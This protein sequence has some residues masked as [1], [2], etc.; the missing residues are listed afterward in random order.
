MN[1]LTSLRD[2]GEALDQE[3]RGPSP[4]LRHTVLTGI[5]AQHGRALR[6]RTSSG[7]SSRSSTAAPAARAPAR[8]LG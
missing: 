2:L 3:L 8:A 1:E 6:A 4:Q 5:G 7:S